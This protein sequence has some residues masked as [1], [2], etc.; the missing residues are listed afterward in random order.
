MFTTSLLYSYAHISPS[1]EELEMTD[2]SVWKWGGC[3]TSVWSPGVGARPQCGGLGWVQ[4]LSVSPGVGAGP[5]CGA[6]WWV[7]DLSV[8][9][10]GGCNTSV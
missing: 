8:E 1:Q 6:L 3:K 10:W 2:T 5:Q 7:Q 9:A 4:H